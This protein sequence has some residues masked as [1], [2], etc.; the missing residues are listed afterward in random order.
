MEEDYKTLKQKFYNNPTINPITNKKL[1]KNKSPYNK[2]VKKFG[3]PYKTNDIDNNILYDQVLPEDMIYQIMLN[4]DVTTLAR[5]CTLNKR[6]SQICQDIRFWINK[7]YNDELPFPNFEL[8]TFNDFK[9]EYEGDNDIVVWLT[10]Y[11][12]MIKSKKEAADILLVNKIEKN[13]IHNKTNGEM[14]ISF[15]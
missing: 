11:E 13:R 1:I 9:E 6:N 10:I 8:N 14:T 7:F 4:S 15:I 2:L 5:L 3:D 12:D